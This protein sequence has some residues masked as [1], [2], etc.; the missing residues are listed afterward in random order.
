MLNFTLLLAGVYEYQ[1]RKHKRFRVGVLTEGF[2]QDGPAVRAQLRTRRHL[3]LVF[4][5]DVDW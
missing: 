5:V 4:H 1:Y 3:P 2:H